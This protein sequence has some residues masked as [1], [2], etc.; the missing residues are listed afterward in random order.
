MMPLSD[1][2]QLMMQSRPE[3]WKYV[4]TSTSSSNST[5]RSTPGVD[6]QAFNFSPSL[7]DTAPMCGFITADQDSQ[8]KI[9]RRQGGNRLFAFA[10]AN[11][12][13]LIS[14]SS[15]AA[16]GRDGRYG[17]GSR[18][19]DGG[20]DAQGVQGAQILGDEWAEHVVTNRAGI[21]LRSSYVVLSF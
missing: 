2:P 18:G 7:N 5:P 21:M 3:I 9:I 19:K 13:S 11:D 10:P 20:T 4:S 16:D 17:Y 6:D 14:R 12:L 1:T 8:I 15:D